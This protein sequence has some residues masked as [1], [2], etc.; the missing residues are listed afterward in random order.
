MEA[1]RNTKR[2][3]RY[4]AEELEKAESAKDIQVSTGR[5]KIVSEILLQAGQ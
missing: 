5:N 2:K 3:L 1:L 4:T